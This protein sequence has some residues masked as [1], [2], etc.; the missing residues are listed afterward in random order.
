MVLSQDCRRFHSQPGGACAIK[1]FANALLTPR[2]AAVLPCRGGTEY[3]RSGHRGWF[4]ERPLRNSVYKSTPP[5]TAS[6]DSLP[7]AGEQEENPQSSNK[8]R[9]STRL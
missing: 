2:R 1:R 5:G 9:K 4:R 7:V 3:R 6:G 8:D